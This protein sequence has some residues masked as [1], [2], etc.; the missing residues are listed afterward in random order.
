[1]GNKK[2]KK[3]VF[4]EDTNPEELEDSSLEELEEPEK[5][6]DSE[7]P[8]VELEDSEELEDPEKLE[9]PGELEDAKLEE[10]EN[11]EELSK[12]SVSKKKSMQGS[13]KMC[14]MFK[15]PSGWMVNP[16]VPGKTVCK[17]NPCAAASC[18][19]K[20]TC[21]L[22]TCPSGYM[23]IPIKKNAHCKN[24]KPGC[25][26]ADCCYRLPAYSGV[27]VTKPLHLLVSL[28]FFVNIYGV[29]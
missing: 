19:I 12:K 24:K 23:T 5:L 2:V 17:S 9:D 20:V 7:E 27:S 29:F 16:K 10:S 3:N 21:D 13:I 15:C 8:K 28:I 25:K 22:F 4:H 1:M 6:E 11:P 26:V 14:N 18:C